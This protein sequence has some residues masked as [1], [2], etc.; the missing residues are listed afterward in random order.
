MRAGPDADSIAANVAATSTSV[1]IPP[2]PARARRVARTSPTAALMSENRS[3]AAARSAR[4]VPLT[5]PRAFAIVAQ[6]MPVA[7]WSA[8]GNGRPVRKT[9]AIGSSS[10]SSV[11]R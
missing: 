7:R 6:P 11:L 2:D 4:S 1:A 10:A 3:Y 8:S 5:W 9:T